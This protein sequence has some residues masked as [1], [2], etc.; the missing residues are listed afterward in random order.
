MAKPQSA[1][2]NGDKISNIRASTADEMIARGFIRSC[3]EADRG[4]S[5]EYELTPK[6]VAYMAWDKPSRFVYNEPE[7]LEE[8]ESPLLNEYFTRVKEHVNRDIKITFDVLE[9]WAEFSGR[10]FR[11]PYEHAKRLLKKDKN[12]KLDITYHADNTLTIKLA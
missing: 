9:W 11:A 2:V 12:A 8:Q 6:G 5:T 4:L 3:F 1:V 7:S 10:H